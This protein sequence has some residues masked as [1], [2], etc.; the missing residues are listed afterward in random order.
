MSATI[1]LV[2]AIVGLLI[3]YHTYGTF[4][5]RRL[6]IEKDRPTPA[7]TQRDGVDYEPAP[8][9][10]VL[11][12]H[13]ASIAGA[14]PIVGP[15]LAVS[16]GWLPAFLWIML[17]SV[18]IGATHD[19]T[20][21]VASL[22][23]QGHTVG[24]LI[25]EYVGIRGKRLFIVFAFSTLILVIAVFANVVQKAFIHSPEVASASTFFVLVAVI[26]GVALRA[27]KLPLLLGTVLGLILLAGAIVLG[28]Q[29]PIAFA[30]FSIAGLTV[31]PAT[32]WIILILAYV[33]VASVSPVWILLQPRDYLNSF[34]LYGMM[35]GAIAGIFFAAPTIQAE[36]FTGWYVAGLGPIFPIL[37]VTVACGAISGFHSLVASGTTSKQLN[38]ESD[39]KFVG[40]GSM[41][42]EAVLAV[43]AL[44]AA[45]Q[46]ASGTYSVTLAEAGPIEIFASGVGSFMTAFGAP[47]QA[48]V[49][50]VSLTISAFALTTLDTCA[51][52]ARM[53]LQEF[54]QNH[55][56]VSEAEPQR[57]TAGLASVFA[58]NRFAA[59]FA[60]ILLGGALTFSGQFAQVWPVFGAANQ[61]LAALALLAV[62]TWLARRGTQNYFVLIPM[63]VMY[64]V[65]VGA[66]GLLIYQNATAGN[67]VLSAISAA[68][69]LLSLELLRQAFGVL[70]MQGASSAP[71]E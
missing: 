58:T 47:E 68:L 24:E 50:F 29:L 27:L 4:V 22:R 41:L 56:K 21:L 23:H 43:I 38:S 17:G 7:H 28:Y 25:E 39:A 14:G 71:A 36:A 3:A 19:F 13:F 16:F 20:S 6:V 12:H 61:L 37:F 42:I 66:L 67:W 59:T 52:L 33:F 70:K 65:T 31:T 57:A 2:V 45:S 44:I 51:R 1:I 69:L 60:V 48:A 46:Y 18:F 49:T 53:L 30:G 55:T 64:V 54:F 32:I 11:G 34:L 9:A 26:F 8:R 62:A 5:S 15:I 35:F 10:V 40:Y 63:F